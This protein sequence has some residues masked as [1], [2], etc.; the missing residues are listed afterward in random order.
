MVDDK[1]GGAGGIG[2]VLV[3]SFARDGTCVVFTDINEETN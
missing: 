1:S 2:R 3:A